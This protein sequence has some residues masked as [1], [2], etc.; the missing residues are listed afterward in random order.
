MSCVLGKNENYCGGKSGFVLSSLLL[1]LIR[2]S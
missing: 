2:I 1:Q